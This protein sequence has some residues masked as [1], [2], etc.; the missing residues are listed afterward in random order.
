MQIRRWLSW[1]GACLARVSLL[2]SLPAR[3]DPATEEY[4][5][6]VNGNSVQIC[7]FECGPTLL[8]QDVSTG[9]VVSLASACF[10][11]LNDG[12]LAFSA[13]GDCYLDECVPPGT[14]RYGL[15]TPLS[16]HDTGCGGGAPFWGSAT[17]TASV[18]ADCSWS[19]GNSPPTPV[20]S[21]AV[22]WPASGEQFQ[23]C[24]VGFGGCASAGSVFS[25]DGCM[26]AF[27]IVLLWRYRRRRSR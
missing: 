8:R 7:F 5:A 3:A 4:S 22:P 20:A 26:L 21:T 14:Y 23:E 6:T 1:G 17:V 25:F 11:E 15:E 13:T 9:A 16:C 27:S 12:G 19:S 10:S 18:A 2:H 24:P